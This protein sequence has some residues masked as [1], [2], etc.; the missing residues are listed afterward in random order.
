MANDENLAGH[1][2]TLLE[3]ESAPL[4]ADVDLWRIGSYRGYTELVGRWSSIV[5]AGAR[6]PMIGRS[7]AGTPLFAL[8][9]GPRDAAR[10]SVVMAG[11]H[12]IEWI[13]VEVALELFESTSIATGRH[14]SSGDGGAAWG[15]GT[16]V[17]RNPSPS[18]RWRQS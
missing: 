15:A 5:R 14:T 13:G 2:A 1:L 8:D 11:I 9:I 10:V 16:M 3:E 4:A 6:A 12:P 17:G 18:P 7:V